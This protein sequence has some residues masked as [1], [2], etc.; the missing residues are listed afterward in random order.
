MAFIG[1]TPTAT[2]LVTLTYADGGEDLNAATTNVSL[3]QLADAV[4]YCQTHG[5]VGSGIW[6]RDEDDGALGTWAFNSGT[7]APNSTTP[8]DWSVT[9]AS[10]Q[11]GDVLHIDAAFYLR[12]PANTTGN[13][14]IGVTHGAGTEY[15]APGSRQLGGTSTDS[16][17]HIVS[18][19]SRV[20]ATASGSTRVR[21]LGKYTG[22]GGQVSLIA[23]GELRVSHIRVP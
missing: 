21:L 20:L 13:I 15:F 11:S 14:R 1:Y 17:D 22:A 9:V 18:M 10:V 5:S 23:Y 16:V 8:T 12:A 7:Y 4:L 3:E 19:H 2:K 6:K